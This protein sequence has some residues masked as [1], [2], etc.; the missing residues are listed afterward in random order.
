[1]KANTIKFSSNKDIL[2][3]N[4]ADTNKLLDIVKSDGVKMY[5]D[6]WKIFRKFVEQSIDTMR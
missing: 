5:M 6:Y 4:L 1:M 2:N 3:L